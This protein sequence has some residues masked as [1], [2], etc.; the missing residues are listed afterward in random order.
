MQCV[1]LAGVFEKFKNSGLK[2]YELCLSHYSSAPPLS[3]DAMLNMAKVDLELISD[4]DMY[5]FFEKGMR[6]TV[7]CISKRYNKPTHKYLKSCNSKKESKD[8][9]YLNANNAY[10]YAMSKFLRTS[11]FKL[12]DH[13]EFDLS[14]YN[15]NSS[16][17]CDLEADLEYPKELCKLHNDYTLSPDII[18]IKSKI[19]PRYQLKKSLLLIN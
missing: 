19:S 4:A 16:K 1:M 18:E 17:G 3:W 8:I 6:S 9:I 2:N 11:A 10:G 5:L 15:S 12:I 13:K 7:F 14:K